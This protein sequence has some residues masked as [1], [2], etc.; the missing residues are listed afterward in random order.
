MPPNLRSR[1]LALLPR[2]PFFF[3]PSGTMERGESAYPRGSD[4]NIVFSGTLTNTQ[5]QW[6]HFLL[7][8]P[9]YIF[10]IAITIF[11]FLHSRNL[12]MCLTSPIRLLFC[13]SRVWL[14]LISICS[15]NHFRS[16]H[17]T[18]FDA[19]LDAVVKRNPLL[20]KTTGRSGYRFSPLKEIRARASSRVEL[21]RTSR[22]VMSEVAFFCNEVLIFA[23]K[24]YY[25]IHLS[26]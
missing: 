24:V 7:L 9:L 2:R 21:T 20:G 10:S 1:H 22:L 6:T 16:R 19:S 26:R 17:T 15:S 3:Y 14:L 25:L 13:D 11:S 5:G 23:D 18:V 12:G 8:F 4:S